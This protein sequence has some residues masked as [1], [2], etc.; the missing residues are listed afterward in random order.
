MI[1]PINFRVAQLAKDGTA[2]FALQHHQ[3]ELPVD[4]NDDVAMYSMPA[5]PHDRV[6][7]HKAR[8]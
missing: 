7:M 2:T 5:S 6:V 4:C 1:K 3:F 8:E